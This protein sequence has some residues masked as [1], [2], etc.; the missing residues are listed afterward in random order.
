MRIVDEDVIVERERRPST[1]KVIRKS[2]KSGL[3]LQLF[4][5][6][7]KLWQILLP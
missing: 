4:I 1:T 7:R 2:V 6:C 3:S 5:N